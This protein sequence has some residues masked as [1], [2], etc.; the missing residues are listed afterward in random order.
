MSVYVGIDVHRKRCQVA[1]VTE[2]GTV[3]LNK[4][5][6]NGMEPFLRLIGDL[7]AG[8]P[9]AFEAAF[10]WSWL[11]DLLEDYGF[12]ARLVHPLRC[13]AIASAR[14]K[15]DKGRRGDL[16]AAAA[17]G[18]A[19][20]SLDRPGGRPSAPRP[21][22]APDQPGPSR[23]QPAEPD[24]RGRRRPRL[25]PVRQLPGPARAAAGW[26]SSTCPPHHGR[27]SPAAWQ[28]PT[29]WRR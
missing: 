29:A 14:L 15:N 11:A 26:P 10:G 23:H 27:S 13:K 1:V 22:P 6:V 20:R 5:T 24:P 28:S 18:P 2:D 9:V 17:R 3:Q 4:N 19:A 8:T 21:D 7:P 25:R 16:G 12:D